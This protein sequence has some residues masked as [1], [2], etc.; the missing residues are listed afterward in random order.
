MKRELIAVV[1]VFLAGRWFWSKSDTTD[2][3]LNKN[4]VICGAS[5]GIGEQLAYRY[6]EQGAHI[7]L[8]ARRENVLENVK[9]NCSRLGASSVS[10][11]TADLSSLEGVQH[12]FEVSVPIAK[13]CMVLDRVK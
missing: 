8:V 1:V 4:V 6:S 13:G 11:V 12:V 9:E 2:T 3:F 10:Y 7:M 5:S